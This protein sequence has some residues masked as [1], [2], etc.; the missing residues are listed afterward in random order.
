MGCILTENRDPDLFAMVV[1]AVWKRRNDMRV[2]KR[3]QNLPNLV[4]QARSRLHDFLLHNSTATTPVGR[5]PTHWQPPAHQR[6]KVNFDGALFKSKS[7][8]EIGVVIRDS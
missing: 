6:Y 1:W 2:G 4:Q 7:Q 5:P 3:G 8:A